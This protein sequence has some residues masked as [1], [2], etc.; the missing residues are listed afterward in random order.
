MSCFKLDSIILPEGLNSL[1]PFAFCQTKMSHIHI[2]A[3]VSIGVNPFLYCNN[4]TCFSGE[5]ASSDGH[6]LICN[7]FLISVAPVGLSDYYIPPGVTTISN[8]ALG[9]VEGITRI[10]LPE[11]LSVIG[12]SAIYGCDSVESIYL[13]ESISTIGP[14]NFHDMANLR[15]YYGKYASEDGRCLIG[16]DGTALMAFAPFGITDYI[17]PDG[18]TSIW[19]SV[20]ANCRSLQSIILPSTITTVGNDA[21]NATG[22]TRITLPDS[23]RSLGKG[24]FASCN[25]LSDI[26]IPAGV[27]SIGSSA[28]A[29]CESLS[30]ITI[31]ATIPFDIGENA[32]YS[33]NDCPIYVP[34][35]SV[36]A[37]KAS[38][39]WSNYANR[40]RGI[41][42]EGS[43]VG[44]DPQNPD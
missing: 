26:T 36:E 44:P 20:F 14:D 16:N 5:M 33:T 19:E 38:S 4:L 17:I 37:Y 11:G 34:N 2:P 15:N 41:D 12:A 13:P 22:I 23:L 18:V 6:S 9:N 10:I 24:A 30:S 43:V 7:N 27:E 32:F 3:S 21:F 28:F 8:H 1:G 40:I 42:V 39:G 25:S 29:H 31:N 35:D